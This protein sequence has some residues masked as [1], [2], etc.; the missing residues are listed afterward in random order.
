MSMR[1]VHARTAALQ[2]TTALVELMAEFHAE[3]GYT[4]DQEAAALSFQRLLANPQLGGVWLATVG[5]QVAGYV[6]LTQR[7]CMDHGAFTAHIEDLYVKPSCRKSGVASALLAALVE[8]CGRRDC[9]S[10]RVEVGH[11]NVPAISLYRRFGLAPF[12][13]GRLLLHGL[14]QSVN[15]ES[16]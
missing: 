3:S 13:D 4:L 12:A 5:N 15:K 11:D 10:I 16:T 14:A 8:D 1:A 2:D 6:A 9:R 7:Y